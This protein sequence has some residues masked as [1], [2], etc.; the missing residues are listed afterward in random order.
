MSSTLIK[1]VFLASVALM[2]GACTTT[3]PRYG[4]ARY[5]GSQQSAYG[6]ANHCQYC[7]T[8]QRIDTVWERDTS[9]GGGTV[10]GAVIG[11][12][13]GTQVGSGTGRKAAMAAGAI[14]GGVIGHQVEQG[15]RAEQPYYQFQ[16]R[17]DDGRM[18]QVTQIENPGLRVGDR[19]Q[20]RNDRVESLRR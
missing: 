2:L 19:V 8:I 12:L 1:V 18:A 4:D 14:A 15:R 13:A 17:L 16:I 10:L 5:Q 6:Y 11:G 9:L 7:G 20:I 3:Q